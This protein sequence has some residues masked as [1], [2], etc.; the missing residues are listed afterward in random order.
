VLGHVSAN[1]D[2]HSCGSRRTASRYGVGEIAGDDSAWEASRSSTAHR[3]A[4]ERPTEFPAG[5]KGEAWAESEDDDELG[6]DDTFASHLH[7]YIFNMCLG[8][9]FYFSYVFGLEI[10][11]H[12][13]HYYAYLLPKK[14]LKSSFTR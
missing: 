13:S 9:F 1:G 6:A 5:W 4:L 11:M 8:K 7:A 2:V 12:P 10:S 3:R 14:T